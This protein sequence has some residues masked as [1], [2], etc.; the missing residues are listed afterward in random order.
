MQERL[1]RALSAGTGAVIAL[2]LV[3]AARPA[4]AQ[5]ERKVELT[6][7]GGYYIAQDIY[8][9]AGS[10]AYDGSTIGLNNSFEYGARL[11][12]YPKPYGGIEFAYTRSGSDVEIKKSVGGYNPQSL[13]SIDYDSWDIN[14]VGR[15]H[16]YS[17][18]KVQGFGTIGF[19]WTTT[20]PNI[21]LLPNTSFSS[22]S[23]FAWNFGLGCNITVSDPVAVRLQGTWKLTNTNITTGSYVYC[24]YYGYCYGYSSDTYSSGDLTAGLTYRFGSK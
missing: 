16:S 10:G 3:F 17:G 1:H 4:A 15:Q 9:V 14:F 20:H 23:L 21:T 11:G 2:A 12:F 8:T 6:P 7:F 5:A 18:S 22:N 19:G 13:G 24:D